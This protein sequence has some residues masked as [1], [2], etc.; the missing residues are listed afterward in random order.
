MRV[1]ASSRAGP[2]LRPWTTVPPIEAAKLAH[3]AQ[4]AL[5]TREWIQTVEAVT[6]QIV[7]SLPEGTMIVASEVGYLGS[8]RQVD[9]IDLVGLN[10]TRLGTRGFSMDYL[11]SGRPDAVWCPMATVLASAPACYATRAFRAVRRLRRRVR[12]W[13]RHWKR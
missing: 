7:R 6:D 13:S 9:V 3:P 8:V 12:L 10:D 4:A 1:T 11:S 5:P 2:G